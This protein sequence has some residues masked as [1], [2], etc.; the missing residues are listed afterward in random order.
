MNN[1]LPGMP[2]VMFPCVDVRDVGYMHYLALIK[3]EIG[4]NRYLCDSGE[5]LWFIDMAK[6]LLAEFG[7]YGY[8]IKTNVIGYWPIKIYSWFNSQAKVILPVMN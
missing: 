2:S 5:S 1:G 8:K 4:G 6:T 7:Q 3:E